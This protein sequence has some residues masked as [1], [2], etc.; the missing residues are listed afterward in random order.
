MFTQSAKV[1]DLIYKAKDYMQEAKLIHDL[2]N[3]R[4]ENAS[5]I[6]DLGCGTG[7][8]AIHLSHIFQYAVTGID[9]NED[10]IRLAV[11]KESAVKFLAADMTDFSLDGK[12]DVAISMFSAIGWLKSIERVQKAFD[13]ASR[14]LAPNGLMIVEPWLSPEEFSVGHIFM[15]AEETDNQKVCRISRTQKIGNVSRIDFHYTV[16]RLDGVETYSEMHEIG[17]YSHEGILQ[18]F[19]NA[20][21]VAEYIR[22]PDKLSGRGL[23]IGRKMETPAPTR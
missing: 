9:I 1:Y 10:M 7:E 13:C 23:F 2:V 3:E 4:H 6:L 19:E 15:D 11:G 18:C 8:H 17:L 14:H 22:L 20:G 21:I 16:G 12:Y 5:S